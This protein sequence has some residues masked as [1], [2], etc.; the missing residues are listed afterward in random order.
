MRLLKKQ[1][2]KN[3]RKTDTHW[4]YD[5]T[6]RQKHREHSRETQAQKKRHQEEEIEK[7]CVSVEQR[8]LLQPVSHKYSQKYSI[9]IPLPAFQTETLGM[10][11][12]K[13]LE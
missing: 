5:E 11:I 8:C 1:W 10:F 12:M 9:N 2:K 13:H 6:Q 4:L 7:N 3:G